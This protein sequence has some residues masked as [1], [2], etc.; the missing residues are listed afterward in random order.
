MRNRTFADLDRVVALGGGHGLGRVMSSLSSLGSRLTGIVTTTDNGGSTGRIRRS[1]G[2]IAWGD[3]RNCI[4]QLIA[5]PSVAS[6]MFEYRFGGNGELSGHNLGNLMLKALDHL[7]VRPL[8][9]INLIRNLLK[10]DAFLIPMSEQPV[11]LVA[12]DHEGHEVYGE[13]NI[14][15]LDHIPQELMLSPPVP[16]TREAVEAIA[17]ADLLLIG[18]GSFYTSLLPILLLDEMA[19]A[20]RRTP[21]PMVF[22]DNLGKEHS[23]A[24]NLT[25]ADRMTILEH[26]VGKKVIDAAIVGPKADVKGMEERLVIQTALDAS[27]VTYRHDRVLLRQA[28]EQAIQALG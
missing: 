23:P 19:Q 25:L 17:E 10:V 5:E 14:D 9:A 12:L 7:S 8:E 3:M 1:E 11:D 15:Q 4:N 27:D 21:A 22:I 2:G 13:V 28:L 24:A 6:A 16:A 18:P 26:Y 20:L